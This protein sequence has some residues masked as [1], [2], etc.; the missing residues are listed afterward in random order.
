MAF[1]PKQVQW[2]RD[3]SVSYEK[4]GDLY[5]ANGDTSTALKSYQDSHEVVKKLAAL[6]PKQ[7][8]WQTDMV[9]S[10]VKLS[11]VEPTKKKQHLQ[12]ALKI[13]ETLNA[14]NRL[15]KDKQ[16]WIDLIKGE[17]GK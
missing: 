6:D 3:L 9:V 7:A 11:Q 4:I 17:L 10:Y 5:K 2:Q 16:A 15:S 1:D 8:Q 13:L 12:D 14:E